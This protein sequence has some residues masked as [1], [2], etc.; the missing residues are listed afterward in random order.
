[1]FQS[2]F[3]REAGLVG[4]RGMRKDLLTGLTQVIINTGKSHK[5][6]R[7]REACSMTWSKFKHLKTK[8]V[9]GVPL[10]SR[11][12]A[13]ES[14]KLPSPKSKTREPEVLTFQVRRRRM[15]ESQK[16]EQEFS[17]AFLSHLGPRMIGWC[18]LTLRGSLPYSAVIQM[19]VSSEHSHL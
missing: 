3:S 8:E 18:S 6:Q 10:R 2:E 11:L 1:M 9:N 15:S 16:I 17:S 13:Q 19:P 7:T 4:Q 5:S 12:M 14:G